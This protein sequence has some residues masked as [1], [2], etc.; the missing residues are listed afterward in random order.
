MRAKIYF[1]I[2]YILCGGFSVFAA[3]FDSIGVEKKGGRITVLHKVE[4]GQS[5]FSI[6]KRYNS[7]FAE[8]YKAN[9]SIKE[10]QEL[11][12]QEIVK[13]P[14]H[15]PTKSVNAPKKEEQSTANTSKPIETPHG[16]KIDEDGIEVVD[17]PDATPKDTETVA[18][19]LPKKVEV[20]GG[21]TPKEAPKKTTSP[22]THM[23]ASGEH[24]FAIAQKYGLKTWQLRLW[25]N[26][27]NDILKVGQKL[28]IEKPA[29]LPVTQPKTDVKP[30]V[31]AKKDTSKAV[32]QGPAG[33]ASKP[34]ATAKAPTVNKPN[35]PVPN[36]PGGRKINDSGIAE[37]M[38]GGEPTTKFLAFHKTAPI[39][40]LVIVKNEAN[41]Q[42]VW[43]KVIGKL[44]E[45]SN[46]I[47]KI[48]PKA[49]E[50][51]LTKDRRIKVTTTYTV[52]N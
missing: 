49:Y 35:Q 11:K 18:N 4:E 23:V 9:P 51:L 21:Q 36:A 12:W 34:K 10:N 41:G 50:R 16:G 3:P 8:F 22:K 29:N 38:E 33:E 5:L 15:K 52:P 13:V 25:N 48:S 47:V 44:S 26:L 45:S 42:S 20:L 39:G 46:A 19:S 27:P 28:I 30:V 6:L 37:L 40:T 1:L 31:A 17:I 7:S 24:L 32:V 14:Y 2:G 43:V